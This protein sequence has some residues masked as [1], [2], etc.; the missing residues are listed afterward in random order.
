[1]DSPASVE[2]ALISVILLCFN[3][4]KY[5]DEALDGLFTQTYSPLDII[6]VDDCS[7]D[8]TADIIEARLARRS[9][10][11]NVRFVRNQRNMVHPI[12]A[13]IGMVA[14]SFIVIACGDDVMLPTMLERMARTWKDEKVSLVTANAL[15][16]DDQS[17]DINR[18][19]RDPNA[20]VD[21]TFETLAKV[22]RQCL[23]LRRAARSS[24]VPSTTISAGRRRTFS[25]QVTSCCPSTLICSTARTSSK[26][27]CSNTA[28]MRATHR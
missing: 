23:L 26:N 20:S 1:M 3:H 25:A 12:P 18:T 2:S 17:N 24:T 10:R 28:C 15:Y 11:S 21:A 5:I 7:S 13:V 27:R 22:R 4:E 9:D 6:I 19:Y 8:R 16:I 14:G